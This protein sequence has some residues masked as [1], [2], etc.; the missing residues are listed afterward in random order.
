LTEQPNPAAGPPNPARSIVGLV[1]GSSSLILA[2]L[3]YMGWAFDSAFYNHFHLDP[4]QLGFGSQEYVLRSLS[5]FSPHIVIVAVALILIVSARTGGE[6]RA[7][8]KAIADGPVRRA[9]Q[10]LLSA[11]P[12]ADRGDDGHPSTVSADPTTR[13]RQAERPV[14][15]PR[16]TK[17]V[18]V[19]AGAVLTVTAVALYWSAMHVRI[20]T[21][22]VLFLLGLGPLLLTWPTRA[23]RLGRGP[24]ALAIVIAAICA[25][26]GTSVYAEQLGN[27]AAENLV[28]NLPT[29]TRVVIYSTQRLALSGPGLSVQP[30]PP[31]SPYHYRYTGLRL[32]LMQSGTY[33]LLPQDW[34]SQLDFTYIINENDQMN[35][36]L[37]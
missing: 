6:L 34:S 4:L 29:R 23:D 16:P 20:S 7:G 14:S 35:I 15:Q 18:L 11:S 26:W 31:G 3:I 27:R 19:S 25:L 2:I 8:V 21:F 5:L 1:V 22:L 13:D 36:E 12:P 37:Y 24:Y 10:W 9:R 32:L 30:L 33:Y 17:T 28:R